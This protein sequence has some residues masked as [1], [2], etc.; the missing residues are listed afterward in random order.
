MARKFA[1][2]TGPTRS[3]LRVHG[4]HDGYFS[5][6]HTT[7]GWRS[8]VRKDRNSANWRPHD[9]LSVNG[10]GGFDVVEPGQ[11]IGWRT[12]GVHGI[13]MYAPKPANSSGRARR[14]SRP[15]FAQLLAT[16]AG[17]SPSV[18]R[19]RRKFAHRSCDRRELAMLSP[20]GHFQVN[21]L[22]FSPDDGTL[23]SRTAVISCF[24]TCR[25]TSPTRRARSRLA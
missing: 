13:W 24:G 18:E 22:A 15:R 17:C 20:Q 12:S 11:T 14:N 9:Q 2:L 5:L 1:L 7:N 4:F 23:P 10:S 21:Y 3:T 16:I 6:S 19:R 25:I 8:P